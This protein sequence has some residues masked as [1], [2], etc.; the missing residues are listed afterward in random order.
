MGKYDSKVQT[1]LGLAGLTIL[2]TA[3]SEDI[4]DEQK[5]KDISAKLHPAVGG[6]HRK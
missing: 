2:C 5:M 3:A 6:K 4:I 1:I